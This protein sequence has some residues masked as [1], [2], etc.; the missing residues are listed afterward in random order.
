MSDTPT[1]EQ[2][3]QALSDY[4]ITYGP[5]M[6]HAGGVLA[7]AARL[8]LE[9]PL[10]DCI[11]CQGSGKVPE[12]HGPWGP[13]WLG[14]QDCQGKGKIPKSWLGPQVDEAM[15]ER[16]AARMTEFLDLARVTERRGAILMGL[17]E[18]LRAALEVTE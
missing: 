9:A 6:D 16:A 15:I 7:A 18:S 17:V 10:V 8:W 1:R 11:G 13:E 14:C 3:Q 4:T 2:V 12:Y 5:G